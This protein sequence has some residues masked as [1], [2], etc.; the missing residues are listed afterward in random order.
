MRG[1]TR[2]RNWLVARAL[3]AIVLLLGVGVSLLTL[4]EVLDQ[5]AEQRGTGCAVPGKDALNASP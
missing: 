1:C 5:V 3:P 2:W 4:L